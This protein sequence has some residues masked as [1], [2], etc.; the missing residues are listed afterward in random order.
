MPIIIRPIS[1]E[2]NCPKDPNQPKAKVG[3]GV[4]LYRLLHQVWLVFLRYPPPFFTVFLQRY[5]GNLVWSLVLEHS[6]GSFAVEMLVEDVE[7]MGQI[8][9]GLGWKFCVFGVGRGDLLTQTTLLPWFC[10]KKKKKNLL[11]FFYL[12]S[13]C[14]ETLI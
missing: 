5:K 6:I 3:F 7:I 13:G 12:S 14:L 2:H 10:K 4:L 1:C 11:P 8:N 9:V